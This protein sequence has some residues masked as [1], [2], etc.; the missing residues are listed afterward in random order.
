MVT[1]IIYGRRS[2]SSAS[3]VLLLEA[4]TH[5]ERFDRLVRL[6]SAERTIGPPEMADTEKHEMRSYSVANGG[7]S[8]G[9]ARKLS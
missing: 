8:P 7:A 4:R 1:K 6:P 5:S 9:P 2:V 3:T